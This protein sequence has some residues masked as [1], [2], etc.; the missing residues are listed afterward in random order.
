[1]AAPL[2]HLAVQDERIL[3]ASARDLYWFDALGNQLKA[4]GTQTLGA[5]VRSLL[6][7]GD[8]FLALTSGQL[9]RLSASGQTLATFNGEGLLSVVRAG[10]YLQVLDNAGRLWR[11]DASLKGNSTPLGVGGKRLFSL[12]GQVLVVAPQRI[13][14]IDTC[15][16]Y[17]SPSPRD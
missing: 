13:Q 12:P 15:L 3:G 9:L 7:D 4:T 14:L 17:T 11:L 2:Q 6:A 8:G 16:L 10:D 5:E 1:M